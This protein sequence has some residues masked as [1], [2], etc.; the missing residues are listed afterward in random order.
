M[1][2]VS[3]QLR[4]FSPV[5]E[6]K[7]HFCIP[8]SH[9]YVYPEK[10]IFG[11][12]RALCRPKKAFFFSYFLNKRAL[13]HQKKAFLSKRHFWKRKKGT[14]SSKKGNFFSYFLNK[15]ALPHQKMHFWKRKRTLSCPKKTFFFLLYSKQKGTLSPKNSTSIQKAF[16]KAEKGHF[17]AQRRHFLLLYSIQKAFL[18]AAKRHFLVTKSHFSSVSETKRQILVK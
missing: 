12:K 14:F 16:L 15:R 2:S 11:A 10:G 6:T 7:G 17:L 18:E 1:S 5:F 3:D 4:H 13:S 9:F 8:K